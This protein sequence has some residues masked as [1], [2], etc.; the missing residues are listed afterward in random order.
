MCSISMLSSMV[1][2]SCPLSRICC[3]NFEFSLFVLMTFMCSLYLILNVRP[4]C[5][6]YF[7]GH[8]PHCNWY[9]PLW[10]YTSE[11]SC[12]CF[13]RCYIVFVV[14]Y[15]ILR[16]VFLNKIV[17]VLVSGPEYVNIVHFCFSFCVCV[18]HTQSH[19]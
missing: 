15:A 18:G 17:I 1:S 13:R 9:T 6:T 5:P 4:V 2:Y 14:L 12:L 11:F 7:S 16:F 3:A 8:L 10:L 19:I